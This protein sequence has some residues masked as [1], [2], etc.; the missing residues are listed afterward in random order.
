MGKDKNGVRN[1]F[2]F[3]EACCLLQTVTGDNLCISRLLFCSLP[4]I[5]TKFFPP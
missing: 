5:L 4:I 1:V 2:M 3:W